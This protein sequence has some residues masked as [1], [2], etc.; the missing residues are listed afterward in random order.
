[1]LRDKILKDK[2]IEGQA[3]KQTSIGVDGLYTLWLHKVIIPTQSPA[4][5]SVWYSQLS[6]IYTGS[7]GNHSKSYGETLSYNFVQTISNK[8]VYM[9]Y[10]SIYIS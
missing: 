8:Y 10:I 1:M 4:S 7:P 9:V 3:S 2:Y 5:S 6:L